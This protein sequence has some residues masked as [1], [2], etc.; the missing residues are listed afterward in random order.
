MLEL[1]QYEDIS[2]QSKLEELLTHVGLFHDG[3]VKEMHIM[4]NAFVRDD[5]AMSCEFSY[6]IRM[7]IQRQYVNPSAIEFI[8]LNVQSLLMKHEIIMNAQESS[9]RFSDEVFDESVEKLLLE[10]KIVS[11]K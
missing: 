7:L 4:N 6:D 2:E 1:N 11:I 3:I 5:L 8:F 9:K 10:L